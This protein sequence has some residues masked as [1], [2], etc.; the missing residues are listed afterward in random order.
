MAVLAFTS[1]EITTGSTEVI[2][3]LFVT[4]LRARCIAPS[5][6]GVVVNTS[7]ILTVRQEDSVARDIEVQVAATVGFGTV[8]WSTTLTS[9]APLTNT[10]VTVGIALTVGNT[11]YWRVRAIDTSGPTNGPWETRS[12]RVL[13]PANADAYEYILTNVG[14]LLQ[15]AKDIYDYV[16]V[17]VG[18]D[19]YMTEDGY[20]YIVLNVGSFLPQSHDGYD[21][22][23]VGDVDT[24]TPTPHIWGLTPT[25]GRPGDGFIIIG[26]G[27]GDLQSTFTGDVQV[28][29]GDGAG[30]NTVSVVDWQMFPADPPMY[31][32]DRQI[33]LVYGIIDPQH[34]EIQ[35]LIPVDALPPGLVVRVR[36]NGP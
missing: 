33:D 26:L 36:T 35:I 29:L 34:Q 11:Y 28:D 1:N 16:L 7:P 24:S 18:A 5:N 9:I 19:L 6:A 21:Y 25:A 3:D 30:W 2:A 13:V 20:E 17:N 23:L 22:V 12:F 31:G 8:L 10:N 14:A 27:F 4:D 15:Q 32:P